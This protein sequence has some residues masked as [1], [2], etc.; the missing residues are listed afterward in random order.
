MQNSP[1][2]AAIRNTGWKAELVLGFSLLG[3]RCA[4]VERR[5]QGPLVVQKP[6]Y[7][8]GTAVCHAVIVHPPGG[9]AGGDAL[10]IDAH[11]GIGAQALI[12]TPGAGKWYKANGRAA[13][14]SL[15]FS[16][17]DGAVMEWLPQ[18]TIVFDQA[19]PQLATR[20]DLRGSACYAGWEILCLGRQA[21]RER[22]DSGLISQRTEIFR[23][24]LA[25]WG[26]Y[27]Q[28]PGGG[29]ILQSPVGLCGKTV[30]ASFL[31]AGPQASPELIQTCREIPAPGGV[32]G[33]TSLPHVLSM[34]Y[35]GDSSEAARQ[36]FES[37]WALLRPWYAGRPSARPRIWNT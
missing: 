22:F 14:Q 27:A 3:S 35:L 26:D 33:I 16:L 10:H 21:A 19:Q 34:R 18:E 12:T 36:Y 15:Q 28:I 1:T 7:P 13:S 2:L 24:G 4:L 31:I 8:E 6:L 5:H 37:L 29:A 25:V 9:I 30:S 11:L 23:D 32:G 20:V 17:Q